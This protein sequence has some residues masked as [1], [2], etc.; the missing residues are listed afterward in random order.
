MLL[1]G[2]RTDAREMATELAVRSPVKSKRNEWP[3]RRYPTLVAEPL[4]VDFAN[5]VRAGGVNADTPHAETKV[6]HRVMLS[7]ACAVHD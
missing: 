6:S 4:P 5:D 2:M 1:S 3:G 7:S